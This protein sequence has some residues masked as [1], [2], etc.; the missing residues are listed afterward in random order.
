MSDLFRDEALDHLA[1]RGR[2]VAPRPDE[3]WVGR[4]YWTFVVLVLLGAL[5]LAL[6]LT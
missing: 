2:T 4:L 5:V 3:T 1:R 6:V